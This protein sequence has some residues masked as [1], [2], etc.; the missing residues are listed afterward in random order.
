MLR[1]VYFNANGPGS[2]FLCCQILLVQT[3]NIF[4]VTDKT[5]LILTNLNNNLSTQDG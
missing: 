2:I 3:S 5:L 4:I 1:I